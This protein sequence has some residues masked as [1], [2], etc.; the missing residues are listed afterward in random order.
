MIDLM[1]ESWGAESWKSNLRTSTGCKR[2]AN[3]RKVVFAGGSFAKGCV[4]LVVSLGEG[5]GVRFRWVVGC[6]FS[7]GK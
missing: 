7:S 4:F 1:K 2:F 5:F 3:S 6:G